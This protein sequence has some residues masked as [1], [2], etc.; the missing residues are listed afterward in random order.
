MNED[1]AIGDSDRQEIKVVIDS[2]EPEQMTNT[3][4]RVGD[5][6]KDKD[7]V[8]SGIPFNI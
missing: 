2:Q 7:G 4:L 3:Y 1:A 8:D 5:D 6:E